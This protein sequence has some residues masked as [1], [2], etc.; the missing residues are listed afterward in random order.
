MQSVRIWGNRKGPIR[1]AR[2]EIP[3]RPRFLHYE[4]HGVP[5]EQYKRSLLHSWRLYKRRNTGLQRFCRALRVL[6][7]CAP[8][9]YLVV[10]E[11]YAFRHE[12]GHQDQ[13]IRDSGYASL[14]RRGGYRHLGIHL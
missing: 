8:P 9:K 11:G 4:S 1:D 13:D 5:I 7:R 6:P 10:A 2:S 14:V 3:Y 12:R